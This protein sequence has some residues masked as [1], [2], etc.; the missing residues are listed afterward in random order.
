MNENLFLR[1]LSILISDPDGNNGEVRKMLIKEINEEL[2]CDS[3][4]E[5][6]IRSSLE[7]EMKE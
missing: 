1:C 7:Q 6:K 4:T 3:Q 2:Y 5:Q